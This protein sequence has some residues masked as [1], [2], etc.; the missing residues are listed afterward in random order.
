MAREYASSIPPHLSNEEKILAFAREFR[1]RL[2]SLISHWL[3]V[4]Y[5]QG[6]F[7][8]DNCAVGGFTL[9]YGPFGFCEAFDPYFQPWTG[10]GRHFS[11]LYQPVAAEQNFNT[12]CAALRPLL[13]HND[14]CLR[15]LEQIEKSFADVMN[16]KLEHMWANKLGLPAFDAELF[17]ELLQL[18]MQTPVDYT[19]F[20][21]E[22]STMP[23]NIQ[24]L[25]KCFYPRSATH[26]PGMSRSM[27]MLDE[28]W[29]HWLQR[30]H[31]MLTAGSHSP[32]RTCMEIEEHMKTVNPKYI[33]R[34]WQMAPV[35]QLAREG[36]YSM[37]NV[38]QEIMNRPYEEQSNNIEDAYYRLRPTELFG[39]GGLSHYS[40]SS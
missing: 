16:R 36:D 7:N 15:E 22:L 31:H 23:N 17:H 3:R 5:C 20:F 35:I 25:K 33:L 1:D 30:W 27:P 10:G 37:I 2:S 26:S 19:I 40:C 28:Q 11:F 14:D 13:L 21:R 9:D 38:I 18:M 32:G 8:S 29:N 12:F 34:E 6:N 24:S 4:G 39:L